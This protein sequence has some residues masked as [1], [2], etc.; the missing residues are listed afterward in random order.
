[1]LAVTSIF[2]KPV[3]EVS[4]MDILK[5]NERFLQ[6]QLKNESIIHERNMEVDDYSAVVKTDET[7]AW[8]F[9]R[10]MRRF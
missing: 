8:P 3:D 9:E 1:M 4:T 10:I 6:L 7:Y 5:K 2:F